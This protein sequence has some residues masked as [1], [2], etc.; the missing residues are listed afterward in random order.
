MVICLFFF[1]V[2]AT[3]LKVDFP[4][5]SIPVPFM[6][7]KDRGF[8]RFD[9][10]RVI[11]MY[12]PAVC[13]HKAYM[14]LELCQKENLVTN[15]W[16]IHRV[17]PFRIERIP[18][19]RFSFPLCCSKERFNFNKKIREDLFNYWRDL[20]DSDT[21]YRE[22][23][24][25]GT[26]TGLGNQYFSKF[27]NIS[28]EMDVY[29]ILAKNSILPTMNHTININKIYDVFY[30]KFNIKPTF[31]CFFMDGYE[32]PVLNELSF[33]FTKDFKLFYDEKFK[34]KF[35][36]CSKEDVY[37]GELSKDSP[38]LGSFMDV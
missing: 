14:D 1:V 2:F 30:K 19:K 10:Y 16:M 33:F 17:Q 5:P 3:S 12:H 24:K 35:W 23:I 4:N 34:S 37:Y 6:G 27:I 32:Q 18:G 29:D 20:K 13:L 22:W 36:E 8:K 28:K 9:L 21:H 15:R 11:F 7:C 38:S 26:C 25:Y 31:G